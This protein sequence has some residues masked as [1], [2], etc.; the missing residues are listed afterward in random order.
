MS[1]PTINFC[2]NATFMGPSTS[3]SAICHCFPEL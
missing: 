3:Y 1:N 2:A